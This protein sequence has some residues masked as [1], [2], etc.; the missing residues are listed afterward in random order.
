MKDRLVVRLWALSVGLAVLFGGHASA[1]TGRIEIPIRQTVLSD[2][3]IRYSVPVSVG[4]GAPLDA[5]LDTGS[6]GLRILSAFVPADQYEATDLERAYPYGGGAR[7]HGVIARAVVKVGDANT[8]QPIPIQVVQSVD[9]TEGR[10]RCP[11][12]KLSPEDYRIGGDGLAKEGF[13]AILGISMR[14]A[15]VEMGANNPLSAVADS[16]IVALPTP[17][18]SQPGRLILNPNADDLGGFKMFALTQQ[19]E[20]GGP[21]GWIDTKLPGCLIDV[22]TKKKLCAP[23]MLDSGAP[24][25]VA[26]S[27]TVKKRASWGRGTPAKIEFSEGQNSMAADFVAGQDHATHV[28]LAP[29][30]RGPM[31]ERI[32]AGTLPFFSL[33]VLYDNKAGAIGLKPRSR[34][35]Q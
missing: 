9:C 7:L 29:L 22:K 10:P 20:R 21:P 28:V 31:G 13:G 6:F 24:G 2:G 3:N 32:V 5:M 17:G 25:I 35:S 8:E 11:A 12:S 4:S 26:F 18:S 33:A 30:Q 15:P 23:V 34:D 19:P 14:T 16:W 1:T 27:S